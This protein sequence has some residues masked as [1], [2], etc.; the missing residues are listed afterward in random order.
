MLWEYFTTP[1][2]LHVFPETK[3]V[4]TSPLSSPSS[5]SSLQTGGVYVREYAACYIGGSSIGHCAAVVNSSSSSSYNMPSLSQSYS[6][7]MALSGYGIIDGGSVSA[8][9]PA[10]P[11]SLPPNTGVVL[12]Q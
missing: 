4:P 9:G 8:S 10:P 7:T 11:S 3:L 12:I 1:S 6:H 5:V 2:G